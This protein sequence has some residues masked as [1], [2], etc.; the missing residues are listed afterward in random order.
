MENLM[1]VADV[2]ETLQLIHDIDAEIAAETTK[3]DQSVAFHREKI[4]RAKEICDTATADAR[5]K[6][7]DL[8]FQLE[9][10]FNANPPSKSKT[11]KFSGGTFGYLKSTTKFFFNGEEVNSDNKHLLDFAKSQ[12]RYE[13]V[14]TKE[15]LDWAKLKNAI[16]F[17]GDSVFF[18]DTGEVIDGLRA[19]KNFTVKTS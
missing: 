11:L 10:Y 13:F 16:D 14:K 15:T 19:Q 18:T 2:E 12:N 4:E 8:V 3:R 9:R 5:L 17:D 7:S 1:T 6:R